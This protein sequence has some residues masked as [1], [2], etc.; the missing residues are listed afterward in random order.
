LITSLL[1]EV[2]GVET[3]LPVLAVLVG[4]EPERR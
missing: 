1:L 2:A 3:T 4:S